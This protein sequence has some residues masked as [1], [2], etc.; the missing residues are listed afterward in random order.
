M[1]EEVKKWLEKKRREMGQA[2]YEK[3]APEPVEKVEPVQPLPEHIQEQM[4]P[5]KIPE[6]QKVE[7][8]EEEPEEVIE[9]APAAKPVET[10]NKIASDMD[11]LKMNDTPIRRGGLFTTRAKVLLVLIIALI[12]FIVYW[13]F[14]YSPML[15]SG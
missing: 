3:P 4:T 15:L 10:Q 9:E 11:V 7:E 2:S 8:V 12:I 14:V 6:P 5:E 1:E 13:T